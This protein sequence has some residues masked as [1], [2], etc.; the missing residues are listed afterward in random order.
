MKKNTIKSIKGFKDILPDE[1]KYY[2]YFELI[3]QKVS[4]QFSIEEL[5]TPIIEKSELF[6]RSIGEGTDIVNKEMYDFI[7]KS[8]DSICLRPE[9]TASIVRSVIEHALVYDRGLKKQK[10]WYHGPMFRHEKP[11]KGRYRQ[12]SQ[13]GV[14]YYGFSD[15]NSELELIMMG[16]SLLHSLNIE[17]ATLH[18]NSLGNKDDK[19]SYEKIIFNHLGKYKSSLDEY[20][21]DTLAKNPLRLLDSKN[22]NIKELLLNVPTLYETLS[23]AS[24]SRFDILLKKLDDLEIHY[25]LDNSIVRGLDYYNDTVFEWRHQSLGS[26]NA[27]CAGGRY[28]ELVNSIGGDDVPAVGFAMGVERIIE[29]LKLTDN[30]KIEPNIVIPIINTSSEEKSYAHLISKNLRQHFD[31]INFYN[32][33][34]SVS[35]TSQLKHA[36][37]INDK[38][39]IIITDANIK[40][41]NLTIKSNE[42][43]MSDTIVSWKELIAYMSN[44]YE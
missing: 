24:K 33:D 39:I 43:R 27:I 3:S 13:F 11:Q 16:N 34:S 36:M 23:D 8:G 37:R 10:Y 20:Q 17:Q 30:L 12:F 26:Q 7:D 2:R 6:N 21:K 32:T 44:K 38:F 42:D 14:E 9:G 35:L 19:K 28:D 31:K 4:K 1:I 5:R 25:L 15:S 29:I 22:D 40:N 41:N 18:I